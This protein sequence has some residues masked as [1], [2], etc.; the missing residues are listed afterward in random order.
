MSYTAK[1]Y[2]G[3]RKINGEKLQRQ[4]TEWC[5]HLV[6]H[7]LLLLA[8]DALRHRRGLGR[9]QVGV[10]RAPGRRP[11]LLFESE[12]LQGYLAHK[13]KHPSRTLP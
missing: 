13:K 9:R 11:R 8:G 5:A 1:S 12:G 7:A 2:N 3:E 10:G 4:R 6:G